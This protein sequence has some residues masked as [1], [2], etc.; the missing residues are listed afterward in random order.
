MSQDPNVPGQPPQPQPPQPGFPQPAQGYP[1]QPQPP[2]AGY[3]QQPQQP[4]PGYPQQGYP[5]QP[6]PGYPQQPQPGYP[7]QG[8]PQQPYA[9]QQ[10]YP[11]A[12]Q[13]PG[14]A[15]QPAGPGGQPP[16]GRASSNK[17]LLIVVGAVVLLVLAGAALLM[18]SN[19]AEPEDPPVVP[20][21]TATVPVP[22]PT[23]EPTATT[24]PTTG[25]TDEPTTEPTEP[26][27]EPTEPSGSDVIDLGGGVMFVPAP[28]WEVQEQAPGAVVVSDGRAVFVTRV[29][30]QKKNT[31]AAQLCDAFNRQILAETTGAKFGEA[32]DLDV[33][34][35]NLAVA[36]CPAAYVSTSN[37]K[38]VQMYA[39]TFAGVRTTDGVVTL[40]TLL[41]TK[42]TPDASFDAVDQMLGIVLTTQSAG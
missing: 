20:Q 42:S 37:G 2:R 12:Y 16:G 35:K 1:P 33:N 25:P 6:Q 3:P 39:V 41:F 22:D 30:Q 9:Q 31:N 21:P 15:G 7:L 23:T 4:Q 18:L 5:Q 32:K 24:E 14:Y 10:A 11:G 27:T 29:G 26:T 17:I 34:L 8:Y 19:R 40:S 28:G 38:S 13:R 36:Q